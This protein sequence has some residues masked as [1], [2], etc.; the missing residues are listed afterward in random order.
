MQQLEDVNDNPRDT[1]SLPDIALYSFDSISDAEPNDVST[2]MKN[3]CLIF[4]RVF[5]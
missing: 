2:Y 5:Y 3:Q 1:M 4:V